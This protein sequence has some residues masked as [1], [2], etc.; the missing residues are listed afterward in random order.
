MF[1][2]NRDF[3]DKKVQFGI[4]QYSDLTDEQFS[5]RVANLKVITDKQNQNDNTQENGKFYGEIPSFLDWTTRS[6]TVGEVR[7]QG[8]W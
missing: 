1:R 7:D 8:E 3:Q 5:E 6:K 4:N 2:L